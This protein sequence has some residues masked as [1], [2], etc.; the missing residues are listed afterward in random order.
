M[1]FTTSLRASIGGL[2]S[3]VTSDTASSRSSPGTLRNTTCV[4]SASSLM[5]WLDLFS[6][7]MR[8]SRVLELPRIR[9]SASP[10]LIIS[11]ANCTELSPPEASMTC[12]SR[13][14]WPMRSSTARILCSLPIRIGSTKPASCAMKAPRRMFSASAAAMATRIGRSTFFAF[15]TIPSKPVRNCSFIVPL[16]DA[17]VRFGRAG[18]RG[19]F[20]NKS[21]LSQSLRHIQDGAEKNCKKLEKGA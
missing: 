12:T 3:S 4:T 21:I 14:A 20:L 17:F 5:R 2:I 9:Q 13:S 15:S 7:G 8:K 10:E 11:M 16:L 6:T 1:F 19:N 18:G